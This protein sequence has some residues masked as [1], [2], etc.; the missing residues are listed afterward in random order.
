MYIYKWLVTSD[1]VLIYFLLFSKTIGE[2]VTQ[3]RT[4]KYVILEVLLPIPSEVSFMGESL[5]RANGLNHDKNLHCKKTTLVT[6]TEQ[7]LETND[8][9]PSSIS[10]FHY[11]RRVWQVVWRKSIE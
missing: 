4:N 3:V 8:K 6:Q 9:P 1:Y 7:Q 11:K 5:F 2:K 10:S